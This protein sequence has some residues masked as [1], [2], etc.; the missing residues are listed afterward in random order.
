MDKFTSMK[1]RIENIETRLQ[2]FFESNAARLFTAESAQRDLAHQLTA[3]MQAGIKVM[4][5]GR[6]LAPNQYSIAVNPVQVDRI[7]TQPTFLE[8][9][10]QSLSSAADHAGVSFLNL[11]VISLDANP[12]MP[13]YEFQVKAEFSSEKLAQTSD[14]EQEP[15]DITT[16]IPENAFLIINGTLV[17]PLELSVLNLGRRPDNHIVIDDQRVSRVHAQLRALKGRYVI[18]DLN[19]TGGTLVNNV[20]IQQAVLY[21][22]DVISLAGVPI[23]YGQEESIVGNTQKYT[24]NAD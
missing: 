4:P 23:V 1:T 6:T 3:A 21:P 11:P 7:I 14:L 2:K 24:P 15:F 16:E 20:R 5:D 18:F 13:L 19:S 17:L 8:D 22:G 9:L 12:E 10:A